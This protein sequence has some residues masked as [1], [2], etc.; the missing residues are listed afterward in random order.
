MK[1]LTPKYNMDPLLDS[2]VSGLI[3]IVHD[4][5]EENILILK[6]SKEV[7]LT[8]KL[9]KG[10]KMVFIPP[11][12]KIK[13]P[14]LCSV[15]YDNDE[16]PLVISTPLF[17]TENTK[18]IIKLLE[19]KC[20]ALH[21]FDENK[22]EF[23]GVDCDINFVNFNID[24]LK[25]LNL[26]E[27]DD[28][29]LLFSIY[30]IDTKYILQEENYIDI[31][32][33]DNGYLSDLTII[34]AT[35]T[36]HNYHG[37]IG[38]SELNHG[39]GVSKLQIEEPGEYQERDIALFLSKIFQQNHIYLNPMND[40]PIKSDR[41]E[42]CDV[43]LITKKNILIIQAKDSPNIERILRQKLERKISNANSNIKKA[44]SQM[45]GAIKELQKNNTLCIYVNDEKHDIDITDKKI[46]GIILIKEY[47]PE[48]HTASK[49][50]LLNISEKKNIQSILMDMYELNIFTS[51]L[52]EDNFFELIEFIFEK[53]KNDASF[54]VR[55]I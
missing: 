18:K 7:I 15:F 44:I 52:N 4:E 42:I 22:R 46:Y 37:A 20:I 51:N 47:F 9:N 13:T 27:R 26:P 32:I 25:K 21:C 5:L 40:K 8:V 35:L 19:F 29:L 23:I 36:S 45:N 16:A 33:K 50:A 30:D 3:A 6:S 12:G 49:D 39:V 31:T 55:M 54:Q 48:N 1:L 24:E 34:D 17:N 28:S 53:R 11:H 2:I 10:F 41:E 43:L 38:K 14:L